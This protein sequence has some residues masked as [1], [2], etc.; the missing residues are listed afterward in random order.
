MSDLDHLTK[1]LGVIETRAIEH[2]L[3]EV[4]TH[5]SAALEAVYKTRDTR[6]YKCGLRTRKGRVYQWLNK[7]PLGGN[8]E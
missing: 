2:D 4:R 3:D 5:V 7:W 1:L 6:E 8:E